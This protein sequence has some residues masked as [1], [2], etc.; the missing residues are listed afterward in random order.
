[1]GALVLCPYLML[2]PY[3][4]CTLHTEPGLDL[5]KSPM[6]LCPA[7]YHDPSNNTK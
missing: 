5:P 6:R 1:M 2:S 4:M 3:L 7:L